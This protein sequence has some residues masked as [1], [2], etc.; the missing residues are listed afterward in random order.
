MYIDADDN[1][2]ALLDMDGFIAAAA[3]AA[4][5]ALLDAATAAAASVSS[6]VTVW[7]VTRDGN[8]APYSTPAMMPLR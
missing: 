6:K 3:A 2:D 1:A 4:I 7:A 8:P 5:A